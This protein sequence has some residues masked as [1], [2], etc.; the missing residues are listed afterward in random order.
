M[1]DT[2]SSSWDSVSETAQDARDATGERL[3]SMREQSAAMSNRLQQQ[4]RSSAQGVSRTTE[5]WANDASR[6][7]REQP[8]VA[9]ALGIALGALLGGLMPTSDKERQL[10]RQAVTSDAGKAAVDRSSEIL[11]T[12][13]DEASEHIAKAG[14][15]IREKVEEVK[16]STTSTTEA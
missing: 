15:V 11:K 16:Q 9:G 10:A 12:A 5:D 13:K 3:H 6:F 2:A 14:E 7:M 8:L 1:T 4:Y